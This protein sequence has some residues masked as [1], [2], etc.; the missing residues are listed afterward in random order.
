MENKFDENIGRSH[1]PTEKWSKEKLEKLFGRGDILSFWVADMD[2][3]APGPLI[4]DLIERAEHGIYGYEYRTDAHHDALIQ[5]LSRRHGW[6]VNKENLLY[7]PGIL[8]ALAIFVNLFS[9]KG[10]KVIIQPPVYPPFSMLVKNND[11]ILVNNRL[12]IVNGRYVMDYED[13][14]KKASDPKTKMMII[15]NPHNPVG[16]VW[17]REELTKLGEIC[18]KHDV[19]LISDDAHADIIFRGHKY[20]PFASI[21]KEFSDGSITTL[22]PA[23]TFNTAGLITAAVI[24]TNQELMTGFKKFLDQYF[25]DRQNVFSNIGFESAYSK[26]EVWLDQ[27]LEY[28]EDNFCFLKDFIKERIPEVKVFETEGTYLV[29]L[30]LSTLGLTGKELNEFLVHEAKIALFPGYWF[31]KEGAQYARWNIGCPKNLLEEGLKRFEA[32][33]RKKLNSK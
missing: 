17:S 26:G 33:V 29:W 23:K 7:S 27:C 25:L 12:K 8:A 1:T 15:S 14:E 18:L 13:L 2:V 16:R 3:N 5:W 30:D 22:S 4:S 9:K 24:S 6:K 28:F 20:V 31:G 11:R 21:S 32:A 19:L 10:E